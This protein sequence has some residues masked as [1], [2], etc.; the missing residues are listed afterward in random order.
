MHILAQCKGDTQTAMLRRKST[1]PRNVW[2]RPVT[3]DEVLAK[4][5]GT[6]GLMTII[7]ERV[8]CQP[9]TIR[10]VR[11]SDPVVSAAITAEKEAALDRIENTM[12][13]KA[14]EGDTQAARLV[15]HAQARQRGYDDRPSVQVDNRQVHLSLTQADSDTLARRC[16][17]LRLLRSVVRADPAT[18]L[19]PGEL[20]NTSSDQIADALQ[21]V[22]DK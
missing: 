13:A 3:S 15:L 18:G 4:I 5:P 10:R 14:V 6:A 7:A 1:R 17:A 20:G 19:L 16:E 21:S 2:N 12:Y 22:K 9:E 8:G 11:D